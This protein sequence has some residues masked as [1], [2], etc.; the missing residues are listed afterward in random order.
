ML[1]RRCLPSLINPFNLCR[2]FVSTG[3]RWQ[4]WEDKLLLD[5]VKQNGPSWSQIVQHGLPHRTTEQCHQRYT[6][7]LRPDL[8][9]GPLTAVERDQL[10]AG[11]AKHG[12]GRWA[13][14]VR[15]FLPQRSPRM[16]ANAWR[17]T[18]GPA[19]QPSRPWTDDE[20]ALLLQVGPSTAASS[21][22]QVTQKHFAWKSPSW[23]KRRYW[24]LTEGQHYDVGR[25]WTESEVHLLL[26]RMTVYGSDW[27]TI[28]AG[29]PGRSAEQCA[30]KARVLDAN[31]AKWSD[32]EVRQLWHWARHYKG[33]WTQVSQ[34]MDDRTPSQCSQQ[35]YYG[36]KELHA[37]GHD[38]A[39]QPD[40]TKPEWIE[41]MANLMCAWLDE[42]DRLTTDGAGALTLKPE[43]RRPLTRRTRRFWTAEENEALIQAVEGKQED[44]TDDATIDW[45]AVAEAIPGK[46]RSAEE[47]R[48]RWRDAA[49]FHD[50]A[51]VKGS[52]TEHEAQL[53]RE[54]VSIFGRDWLAVS[55]SFVPHRT[56]RQCML[57]WSSHGEKEQKKG[58]W[59]L[60]ED[61]TLQLGVRDYGEQWSRIASLIPGRSPTQCYERWNEISNP[62]I[63]KGRWSYEEESQLVELAYKHEGNSQRWQAVAKDMGTGR[64]PSAYR[65]KFRYLNKQ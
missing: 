31:P 13:A 57:W 54:G 35:F 63:K 33:K 6:D 21:W 1:A 26:R 44:A 12:T 52:I 61:R 14:I 51:I 25:H 53:I 10:V 45:A 27:H 56:P 20:D 64:T 65:Q 39:R 16:L 42:K 58:R 40:E 29:L 30:N 60:P 9:R 28:A 4:P 38:M 7:V 22:T 23:V 17:L 34:S 48:V 49:R 37:L 11:V 55:E 18:V 15:E 5:Y 36:L 24:Q 8:R 62:Q 2:R 47:C 41:R 32:D 59:T 50:R 43:R 19:T 3:S 46:T